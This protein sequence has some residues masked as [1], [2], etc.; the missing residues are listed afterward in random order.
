MIEPF[1]HLVDR[2]VLEIQSHIKMKDY[3]FSREG[4]VVLSDELKRKYIDLLSSTFDRKR[5]YKA[6]TGIRR[7]DGFQ[8]MEE[9]TI[10]K[11]KCIGLKDLIIN[12]NICTTS[13]VQNL[14][15]PRT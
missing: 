2:S 3:A 10:M 7:V 4:T 5:D 1:R 15:A 12:S 8:K 9:I 14:V 6:R 13:A 11:M